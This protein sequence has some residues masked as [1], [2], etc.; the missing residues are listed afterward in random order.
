MS[1]VVAFA[2]ASALACSAHAAGYADPDGADTE[3]AANAAV[4]AL[5]TNPA[6]AIV[7]TVRTI[8]ALQQ[9]AAAGSRALAATV[10]DLHGAMK[11]LE[12]EETELEVRI[13]LPAD[14]LFDVDRADIRPDAA[15]ALTDLAT[16]VRAWTGPVRL[17]G[18]TDSDGSDAH[19]LALSQRRAEAVKRWLVEH[20]AIDAG[21]FVTEGLGETAPRAAND[22]PAGKQANRR[23]EVVVR[24]S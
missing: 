4:A 3:A 9:G 6:R 22:T 20:A 10:K 21:R 1:R 2:L 15:A 23:V 13:E 17:V 12:G 11:A 18:H 19:N 14:V 8:A 5:G 7:P 24:K 16:V